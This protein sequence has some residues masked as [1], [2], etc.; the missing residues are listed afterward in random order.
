[1]HY[2]DQYAQLSERSKR[3]YRKAMLDGYNVLLF[4][5]VGDDQHLLKQ[6]ILDKAKPLNEFD[7]GQ[8]RISE[9]LDTMSK[10]YIALPSKQEKKLLLGVTK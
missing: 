5:L 3:C 7:M 6:D 8:K 10:L 4:A 2:T 9:L 1:W